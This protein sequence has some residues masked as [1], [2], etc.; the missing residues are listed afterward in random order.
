MKSAEIDVS[1]KTMPWR[2]TARGDRV[3]REFKNTAYL[4]LIQ[5]LSL[6]QGPSG[7][8]K[9]LQALDDA[10]LDLTVLPM[11]AKRFVEAIK[12]DAVPMGA[13][14]GPGNAWMP[15]LTIRDPRLCGSPLSPSTSSD[16]RVLSART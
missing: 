8:H 1:H 7:P 2:S 12:T 16:L 10:G 4:D 9:G 11:V 5:A 14:P 6:T 3:P 13:R 15:W